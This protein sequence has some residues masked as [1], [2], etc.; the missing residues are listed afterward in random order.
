MWKSV[1]FDKSTEINAAPP[2]FLCLNEINGP[3]L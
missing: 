1:I 3:A 2:V